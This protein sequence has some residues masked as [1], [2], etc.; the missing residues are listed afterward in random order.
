MGAKRLPDQRGWVS[1]RQQATRTSVTAS[2]PCKKSRYRFHREPE[3]LLAV[4]D[5]V[6]TDID[7]LQ[8]LTLILHR[9]NILRLPKVD[10]Q[11]QQFFL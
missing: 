9:S 1:L 7:T 8:R 6:P 10:I 5:T 4:V 2:Q 11:L 3:V